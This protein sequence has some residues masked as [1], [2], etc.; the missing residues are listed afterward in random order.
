MT[1]TKEQ[2]L[3]KLFNNSA[4]EEE[5]RLLF[6]LIQKDKEDVGPEI[7]LELL[8]QM[9]KIPT[10]KADTSQRIFNEVSNAIDQPAKKAKAVAL[11]PRRSFFFTRKVAAAVLLLMAV[12]W[13]IYQWSSPK[14][15]HAATTNGEIRKID[16]PDGSIVTL[17]ENSIIHYPTDW[18]K[19]ETRKVKL[20]GEAYFEIEKKVSTNA[21]FQVI[22]KDL[23]VE[24]FG[25]VFNVNTRHKATKVYLEE[26]IVK[27][28]LENK[29]SCLL[30]TS[31]S[32]RD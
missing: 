5:L 24:V 9:G 23:M 2:L 7:M 31:P 20:E 14:M 4:S 21:K 8:E 15:L 30:Y 13:S 28:N 26:G 16:L 11:Q 17:N 6:D 1:K 29:N 27:V 18:S 3:Q 12:G 19:G 32:P 22:T 25:T 10:L